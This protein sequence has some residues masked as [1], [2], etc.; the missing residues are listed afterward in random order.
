MDATVPRPKAV[1]SWPCFKVASSAFDRPCLF[2]DAVLSML[3]LSVSSD[4]RESWPRRLA[5]VPMLTMAT[6]AICCA[7]FEMGGV[8]CRSHD[9]GARERLCFEM[10]GV[11]CVRVTRAPARR[12]RLRPRHAQHRKTAARTPKRSQHGLVLPRVDW[13]RLS[14]HSNTISL[15]RAA[16]AREPLRL[17]ASAT[18]H[19]ASRLA[20]SSVYSYAANP[21]RA[22]LLVRRSQACRPRCSAASPPPARRSRRRRSRCRTTRRRPRCPR[23]RRRRRRSR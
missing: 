12:A 19:A 13:L 7:S 10:S 21:P 1:M 4:W 3:A 17:S 23:A 20:S 14:C 9:G 5:N 8:S 22:A 2:A 15:A 11:S 6:R 18:V 16:A